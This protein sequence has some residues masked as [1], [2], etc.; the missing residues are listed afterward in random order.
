MSTVDD[1]AEPR[2][3]LDEIEAE[4]KD[5]GE[6]MSPTADGGPMDP[7]YQYV[8]EAASEFP[9][10]RSASGYNPPGGAGLTPSPSESRIEA[11]LDGLATRFEL[12]S[13]KLRDAVVELLHEVKRQRESG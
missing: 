3:N 6:L 11:K 12:V 8:P 9:G 13:G 2:P 10:V 1:L 5:L 7:A 4:L